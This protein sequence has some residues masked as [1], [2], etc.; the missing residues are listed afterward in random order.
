MKAVDFLLQYNSALHEIYYLEDL[1][2]LSPKAMR[3]EHQKRIDKL[4]EKC[5]KV[6]AVIDKISDPKMRMILKYR[7][8]SGNTWEKVSE[9]SF[10]SERH[11]YRLHKRAL[12]EIEKILK[13]EK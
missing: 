6:T 5:L 10:M 1:I 8:I 3:K 11:I 13:G 12:E 9:L 4:K 2:E 7:Y